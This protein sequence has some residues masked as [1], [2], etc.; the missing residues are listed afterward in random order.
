MG[1]DVRHEWAAMRHRTIA[2]VDYDPKWPESFEAE[3]ELLSRT[4]GKVAS[5]I[6]HIGST[7]VPG[8]AAK[9]IIDILLESHQS[10]SSRCH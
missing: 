10:G 8:L 1:Y 3:C 2:V 6:D 7:V 9:P 5:R 4:L